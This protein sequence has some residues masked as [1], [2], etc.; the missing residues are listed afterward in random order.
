MNGWKETQNKVSKGDH[1]KT[2]PIHTYVRTLQLPNVEL[3]D[4]VLCTTFV[5]SVAAIGV[6]VGSLV[7]LLALPHRTSIDASTY[8]TNAPTN[9]VY[10]C[11]IY[12]YTY[13]WHM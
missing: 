3:N 2:T 6:Q 10:T 13:V 9:V 11:G 5:V 1:N 4:G 8:Y 12:R 7:S